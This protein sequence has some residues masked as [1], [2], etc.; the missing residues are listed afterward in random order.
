MHMLRYSQVE[1]L[2]AW[3]PRRSTP[4]RF[5][6][7]GRIRYRF[8]T[9]RSHLSHDCLLRRLTHCSGAPG[10]RCPWRQW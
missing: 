1:E 8:I 5:A 2:I 9:G 4:W 6:V 7:A 3:L 10:A